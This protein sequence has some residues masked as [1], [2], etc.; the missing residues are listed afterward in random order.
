M[1][2]YLIGHIG[3]VIRSQFVAQTFSVRRMDVAKIL[4]A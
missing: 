2:S 3:Q 4:S 1:Y